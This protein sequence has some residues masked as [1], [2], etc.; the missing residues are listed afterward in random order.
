MATTRWKWNS[1]TWTTWHRS[2]WQRAILDAYSDSSRPKSRLNTSV[3]KLNLK[4]KLSWLPMYSEWHATCLAVEP[5]NFMLASFPLSNL[6]KSSLTLDRWTSRRFAEHLIYHAICPPLL[7][8]NTFFHPRSLTGHLFSTKLVNRCQFRLIF[9]SDGQSHWRPSDSPPVN[10]SDGPNSHVMQQN[11]C[12]FRPMI[13]CNTYFRDFYFLSILVKWKW[14][15]T[16]DLSDLFI[17]S[18]NS[19]C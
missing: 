5:S 9:M 4:Y 17:I 8:C 14:E 6:A 10:Q 13:E 19:K 15:L 16:M 18:M 3:V 1:S 11:N 7:S 2:T 12:D